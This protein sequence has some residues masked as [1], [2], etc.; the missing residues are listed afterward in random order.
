MI[1][2]KLIKF[3]RSFEFLRLNGF[4]YFTSIWVKKVFEFDISIDAHTKK[5]RVYDKQVSLRIVSSKRSF[6]Q[7]PMSSHECA[8]HKMSYE[9]IGKTLSSFW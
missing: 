3:S 7:A 2:I 4:H 5:K 6:R 9:F 8:A 1:T